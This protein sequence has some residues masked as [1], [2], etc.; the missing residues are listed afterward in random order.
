[1]SEYSIEFRTIKPSQATLTL[2]EGIKLKC[3]GWDSF[4]FA[5]VDMHPAWNVTEHPETTIYYYFVPPCIHI[6]HQFR[7][8][9]VE[10]YE[11]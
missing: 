7:M 9:L 10:A 11:I 4:M 8:C 2:K 6:S 5:Y 3:H 1:M